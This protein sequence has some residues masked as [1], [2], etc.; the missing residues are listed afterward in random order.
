[1]GGVWS[2]LNLPENQET[3]ELKKQIKQNFG[4]EAVK[5]SLEKL[6]F[7][8]PDKP[9]RIGESWSKTA[10]V[11]QGFP[12]TMTTTWTL[13]ERRNDAWIIDM[14]SIVEPNKE[15][16]PLKLGPLT[17][18]Y[19]LSGSQKGS[20]SI[21]SRTGLN[22]SGTILQDFRGTVRMSMEGLDT[23]PLSWPITIESRTTYETFL[24]PEKE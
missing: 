13:K 22:A 14:R 12:M 7:L 5:E 18:G 20:F 4:E 16:P 24:A 11:T 3:E 9:V 8:Y 15:A 19:S 21:D 1:M 2:T 23:G 6:T 17:L 10:A